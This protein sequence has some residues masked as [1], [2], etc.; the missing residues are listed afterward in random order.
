MF[1]NKNFLCFVV[2]LQKSYISEKPCSWDIGQ[3]ALSQSDCRI[4][5][6]IIFP[7]EINETASFLACWYK[8]T[9]I[10]SWSN[11][12]CLVVVKNGDGQSGLWT[13]KLT[14]SQEWTDGINC[15]LKTDWKFMRLAWS[16][17]GVTIHAMGLKN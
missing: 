4:F 1:Y 8:F 10:K 14:V 9:K 3:N 16:K 13:L 17:M 7:E 11:I 12:F 6:S 5:K 2:F 15:E